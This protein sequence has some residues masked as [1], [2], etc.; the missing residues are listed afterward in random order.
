[1]LN[2]SDLAMSQNG[3]MASCSMMATGGTAAANTWTGVED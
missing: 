2:R 1:M 3:K